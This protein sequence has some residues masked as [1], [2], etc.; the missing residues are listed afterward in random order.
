MAFVVEDGTG[1][2]T[3]NAYS[4]VIFADEYFAERGNASWSLLT[5]AVKQS[6]LILATDYID[7][8]FGCFFKGSML[9]STQALAFPRDSFLTDEGLGIVPEV[10]KKATAE[11]AIRASSAQLAPDVEQDPSGYQVSRKFE[12]VGPIEE[13]TDFAFLGSGASRKLL[14]PYPAAD[15]LLRTLIASFQGRVIRN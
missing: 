1:L 10:L 12:K 14:K 15:M 8:V 9:T 2:S 7:K 4:D 6:S 5:I 3:A 13:R 11:Y